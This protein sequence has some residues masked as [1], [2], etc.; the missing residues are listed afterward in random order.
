M[1]EKVKKVIKV[2]YG[3]TFVIE[4]MMETPVGINLKVRSVWIVRKAEVNPRLVTC[5]PL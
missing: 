5:Y 4:G 3:V 1:K 2:S